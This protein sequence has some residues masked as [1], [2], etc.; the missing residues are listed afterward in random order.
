MTST[1]IIPDSGI[2]SPLQYGGRI[3]RA[4]EA[5][6]DEPSL[7]ELIEVWR[8]DLIELK[9][10]AAVRLYDSTNELLLGELWMHRGLMAQYIVDAQAFL[11]K[12]AAHL[13]ESPVDAKL[14]TFI[15]EI[16]RDIVELVDTLHRWHGSPES[17]RDF[18]DELLESMEEVANGVLVDFN[19]AP[20]AAGSPH[21][22]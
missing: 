3:A 2:R 17:Q 22:H 20:D 11:L 1:T 7:E 12:F 6:K 21:S 13:V 19:D 14:P 10:T 18:P 8:A 15:E 5:K 16:E 4:W 9:K